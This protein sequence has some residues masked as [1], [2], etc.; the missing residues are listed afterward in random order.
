HSLETGIQT[1]ALRIN[2]ALDEARVEEWR[3]RVAERKP[4][5]GAALDDEPRRHD[6]A[7]RRPVPGRESP[8]RGHVVLAEPRLREHLAGDEETDLDPHACEPNALA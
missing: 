7:P 2:D 1:F 5:R 8:G 6:P 4:H 3:E